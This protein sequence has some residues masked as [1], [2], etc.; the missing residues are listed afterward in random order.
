MIDLAADAAAIFADP[1]GFGEDATYLPDFGAS[2][3]VRVIR[4]QPD[5][6]VG[7]GGAQIA[8][9]TTTFLVPVAQVAAPKSGDVI[10]LAGTDYTIRGEPLR[11]ANRLWWRVEASPE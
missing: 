7:F 2:V 11:D 1:Q 9:P 6:T 10:A 8:G 3:V 5:E 4:S